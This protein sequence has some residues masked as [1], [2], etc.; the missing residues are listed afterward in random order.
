MNQVTSH[1]SVTFF[2]LPVALQFK[3][4]TQ[5]ATVIVD[6]TTNGEIFLKS[7]GFVPD[8]VF[9]DPEAWLI[10]RNNTSQKLPACSTVSGLASSV[11]TTTT[12]TVSWSALNGAGNY[13]VDYKPASSGTWINAASATTSL[14]INL[15][16]LNAWFAVRLEGKRQLHI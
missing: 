7:V 15:R 4:A 3:N 2:E 16:R 1:A 8:T 5:Q 13:T 12:A 9:I 10:T 14:S 11:I 6:N